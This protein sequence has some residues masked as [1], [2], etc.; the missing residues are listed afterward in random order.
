LNKCK[1]FINISDN[2]DILE[3]ESEYNHLDKEFDASI[4]ITNHKIKEEIRKR[5]IP[6]VYWTSSK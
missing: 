5:S 3:Y 2:K 1:S 6:M 4:S